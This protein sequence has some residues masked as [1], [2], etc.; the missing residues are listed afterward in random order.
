MPVAYSTDLRW[1]IILLSS[2]GFLPSYISSALCISESTVYRIFHL[3]QQTGDVVP[4]TRRYGRHPL[5][6]A[7]EQ[8]VLLRLILE[9]VG[10]Y[11]HELQEML[12]DILGLKLVYLPSVEHLKKWDAVGESFSILQY[13][14]QKC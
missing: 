3:F 11:L 7:H 10:I 14:N 6:G 2:R 12:Q 1:R 5:F 13:S 4:C 8:L 9:N